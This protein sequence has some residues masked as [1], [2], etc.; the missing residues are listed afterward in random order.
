MADNV[1][2]TE[3][4]QA[5]KDLATSMGLSVKEYVEAGF[6]GVGDYAADKASILKRLDAI[7]LVNADDDIDSLAEKISA[8]NKVLSNDDGALQGIL[9]LINKNKADLAATQTAVDGVKGSVDTLTTKVATASTDIEA[10]KTAVADNKT[11]QA[12]KNGALDTSIASVQ[13]DVDKLKAGADVEG[14]IAYS[15]DQ[16]A[17]RAK[18]EVAAATA[19]LQGKIDTLTAGADVEGSIVNEIKTAV[20][21]IKIPDLTSVKD[22]VSAEEAETA[23]IKG[24]LNDTTDADGN[25]VKGVVSKLD[26]A[27]AAIAK[28]AQDR[29]AAL[30]A[31]LAE[32]KAYTDTVTLKAST[33]DICAIGN[34]FR[35]AFGLGDKTCS[36][37]SDS[38]DGATL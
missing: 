24:I 6:V 15:V 2:T 14:S 17:K 21:N 26:E 12:A 25:L 33:M 3:L 20:D 8:I 30:E 34:V 35:G 27:Q 7:D 29:I 13:G 23:V 32:A 16:E 22:R 4:E 31:Q 5:L 38:G 19:D 9:D 28:E 37:N 36:D 18:A 11:A 1:T 10:I